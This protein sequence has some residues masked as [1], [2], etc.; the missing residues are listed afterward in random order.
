MS[1]L[2]LYAT[3]TGTAQNV[4]DRIALLCRRIHLRAR[5]CNV[6]DYPPESLISESLVIFVVS[7]TGSGLEP[8][9]MKPLWTMLLR[10]D[11]PETL[12]DECGFAVFGLG[13]SAYDR[14]CWPAKKVSRRMKALGG[15]EIYEHGEGDE[16]HMLGCVIHCGRWVGCNLFLL[17]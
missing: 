16:Q 15:R 17:A 13:D 11:L 6:A 12:F 10:A 8:R 14:F 2:I 5:V 7:T 1:V 9:S 4:A 3:E